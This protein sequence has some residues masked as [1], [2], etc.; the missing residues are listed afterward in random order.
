[1][2]RVGTRSLSRRGRY[3]I[4]SSRRGWWLATAGARR[5]EEETTVVEIAHEALLRQWPTLTAWL[6][7][8]ADGLKALGAVQRAAGE[9]HK[10]QQGVAWLVHT[11]ER[12]EAAEAQQRRP[13]FVRLLGAEGQVYLRACRDRD[14]SARKQ[15]EDARQRDLEAARRIAEEAENTASLSPVFW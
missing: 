4:A 15:T 5:T 14:D 12:L 11:G 3:W 1:V 10:K 7:Q 9:W 2:W 8:D 13:D 6:D